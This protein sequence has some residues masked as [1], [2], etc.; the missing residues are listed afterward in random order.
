MDP[1]DTNEEVEAEEPS[2]E[3]LQEKLKTLEEQSTEKDAELTKLREKDMNFSSFRKKSKEEQ[4][5]IR[6]KMTV[7]QR[8]MMDE[9]DELR[10]QLQKRDD[11]T[12]GKHKE[13]KRKELAGGDE[14]LQEKLEAEYERLGGD[15]LSKEAISEQYED[16]F[17]LV[18]RRMDVTR[19][20]NPLN[21]YVPPS[22][23]ESPWGQ[24]QAKSHADT[25]QGKTLGKELGLKL[26]PRKL[27]K[28]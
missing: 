12:L 23:G 4:V 27:D 14:K 16:A 26:E 25:E 15:P 13:E 2:V 21:N 7:E 1:N 22:G 9:M 19:P 18:Q 5:K 20:A 11:A 10:G 24:R 28:K 17:A 6:E 8:M 3:E